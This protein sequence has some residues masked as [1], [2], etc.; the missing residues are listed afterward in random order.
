MPE[1]SNIVRVP[2]GDVELALHDFGGCGPILLLAHANGFPAMCYEPLVP[3][4]SRVPPESPLPRV[5]LSSLWDPQGRALRA[6]LPLKAMA[7]F[8]R[9]ELLVLLVWVCP[10]RCSPL[11]LELR[12][13]LF[14]LLL[15]LLYLLNFYPLP[16]CVPGL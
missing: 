2:C 9:K 7:F 4:Q 13:L 6:S 12:L 8:P 11:P 5:C 10:L 14:L 16:G 3:P 1:S 15:L